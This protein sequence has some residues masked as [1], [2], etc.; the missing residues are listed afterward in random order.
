MLTRFHRVLVT[1]PHTD[2]GELG[3]GGTIARLVEAGAEVYYLAFST[4]AT[5]AHIGEFRA[6][7][8]VL[9]IPEEHLRMLD[10]KAR[11]FPQQRQEILQILVD[12]RDSF[13]PD[14]VL[15]P[16]ARD[17]H[18]D[19]Q[20]VAAEAIRAFRA[21]TLL[22]YEL[23]WNGVSAFDVRCY[24]PLAGEHLRRKIAALH[25]YESQSEKAYTQPDFIAGLARMR[26]VQAGV[27]LA[28]AF[29]VVRWVVN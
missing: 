11:Y 21:T 28:E 26:G 5:T 6:A 8:E 1:A 7:M 10:F 3:A 2:D 12:F 18:Q 13:K 15:C 19:H 16:S 23:P 9:E 24:V 4:G 20:V 14:L 25:Q 27:P 17:A 22:G 29:E